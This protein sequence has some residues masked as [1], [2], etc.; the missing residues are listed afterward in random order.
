[1]PSVG[2]SA[3]CERTI[4]NASPGADVLLR[5]LDRALVLERPGER[6]VPALRRLGPPRREAAKLSEQ[7]LGDLG[8]VAAEHLREP[9]DVVEADQHVG[10][11]EAALR[12]PWSGVRQRHGRLELGDV[13]VGEVADDGLAAGLGLLDVDEP[14]AVADERV[15]SETPVLD[16][17]EQERG[18]AALRAQPEVGPERSDE[19]GCDDGYRVHDG[20][21]FG[22][23]KRPPSRVGLRRNGLWA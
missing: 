11:D 22:Q 5:R 17:L 1:M 19:I 18:P 14:R 2:R 15:L 21:I 9:G 16:G 8:R 7:L 4:W 6:N 23:Q 20:F 13:V 12:K 3:R 10:D